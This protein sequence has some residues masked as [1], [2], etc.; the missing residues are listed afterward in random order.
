MEEKQEELNENKNSNSRLIGIIAVL[1]IILL[2]LAIVFG[3]FLSRSAKSTVKDVAKVVKKADIIGAIDLIDPEG[4]AAFVT[5]YNYRSGEMDLED[6]DENYEKIGKAVKKV[7]NEIKKGKYTIDVTETEKVS[8]SKKLTKVTC[9][10]KVK[11]KN[12][13]I[14]LKGI[15]I[16]TMKK[17]LKNYIV[18][19]DSESINK[20]AY[21]L[22]DQEDELEGMVD[23]LEDIIDDLED[24]F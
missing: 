8:G 17:G 6:F 14:K 2:V 15:E 4:I 11:Y 20:A 16:Y 24:I 22:E 3:V 5:C 23:D 13:E 19:I 10:I 9:D 21:K 1:V 12:N 18:G 7:K